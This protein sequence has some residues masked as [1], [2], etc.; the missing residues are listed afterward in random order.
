M[1]EVVV[2]ISSGGGPHLEYMTYGLW[3]LQGEHRKRV[4]YEY[5][6]VLACCLQLYKVR[7]NYDFF[8]C[9]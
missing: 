3:V 2:A 6:V 9:K 4:A 1:V 5:I 8:F 7:I